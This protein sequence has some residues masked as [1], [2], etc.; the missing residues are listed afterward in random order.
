MCYT[1]Q[2]ISIGV[3]L[4]ET[5]S[6][7][8]LLILDHIKKVQQEKG[9]PPSVREICLAVG[10]KSPSTVHSHL[11]KLE[12]KGLIRR[13]PTKPRAIEILDE[14][15]SWMNDHVTPVP[16]LGTVTAGL[17]ILATENI[18]EYYPLPNHM[19]R[20]KEVY[21]LRVSGESMI[22]AGILDKDFIIVN[23][24]ESAQNGDIIVA[25]IDD[26]VTVKRFFKEEDR[27]RLQPE[28]DTMSPMYFE[29][30][31]VIG[32]VVGLFREM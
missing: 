30:L 27:I 4:M 16:V 10:L 8:Q 1:K 13:D 2:K 22:N 12:E 20:N 17:P 11:N 29:T 32:K 15:K 19:T 3:A 18:E 28:N 26:E 7:K 14:T 23:Q 9:Y 31:K 5:L 21:M 6:A 25:L 24:Q